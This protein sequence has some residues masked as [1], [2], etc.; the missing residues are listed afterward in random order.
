MLDPQPTRRGNSPGKDLCPRR[1]G[2]AGE[3]IRRV[4]PF[5]M[6]AQWVGGGKGNL[7][8]ADAGVSFLPCGKS[9]GDCCVI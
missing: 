5:A 6:I 8:F 2:C 3:E 4:F 9:D 7:H 1:E